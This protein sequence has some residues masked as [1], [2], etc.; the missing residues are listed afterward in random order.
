MTGA[1]HNYAEELA[2]HLLVPCPVCKEKQSTR[3]T[4]TGR[5][6]A[7]KV[8]VM[9]ASVETSAIYC[10]TCKTWVSIKVEII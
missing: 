7:R 6:S 4:K 1:E 2:R 9:Q 3:T 10:E 5:R 8:P